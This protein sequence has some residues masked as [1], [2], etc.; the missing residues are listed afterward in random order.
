MR[1]DKIVAN[2]NRHEVDASRRTNV[3]ASQVFRGGIV[4]DT[5]T[6]QPQKPPA[7]AAGNV[8]DLLLADTEEGHHGAQ[9]GADF[10]DLV[11]AVGLA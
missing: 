2:G 9:A 10:L 11:L 4:P 1:L 6:F 5:G 8:G 7:S 3:D